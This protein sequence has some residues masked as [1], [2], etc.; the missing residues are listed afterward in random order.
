M[1]VESAM[2]T[3]FLELIHFGFGGTG[4]CSNVYGEDGYGCICRR[5]FSFD[6]LFQSVVPHVLSGVTFILSVTS[7]TS[8]HCFFSPYI[9]V[10]TLDVRH[11]NSRHTPN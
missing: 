8:K 6:V 9:S 11:K 4:E 2:S 3:V 5:I 1:A 7:F 10:K